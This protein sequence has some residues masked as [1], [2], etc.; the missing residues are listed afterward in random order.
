MKTPRFTEDEYYALIDDAM[1]GNGGDPPLDFV[2]GPKEWNVFYAALKRWAT[3][4]AQAVAEG[5]DTLALEQEHET[6]KEP[7]DG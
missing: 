5:A 4:Q 7:G 6:P 1:N 2:A 3:D